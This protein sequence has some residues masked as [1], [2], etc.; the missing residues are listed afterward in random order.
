MAADVRQ[1]MAIE[2]EGSSVTFSIIRSGFSRGG[3]GLSEFCAWLRNKK[4]IAKTTIMKR[5][6]ASINVQDFISICLLV[7]SIIPGTD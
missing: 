4:K 7:L 5:C 2:V 6:I 1:V 3:K